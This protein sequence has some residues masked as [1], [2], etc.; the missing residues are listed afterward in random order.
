MGRSVCSPDIGFGYGRLVYFQY[1]KIG[2]S[3]A[4]F[5]CC[6]RNKSFDKQKEDD[7][8]K[9]CFFKATDNSGRADLRCFALYSNQFSAVRDSRISGGCSRFRQSGI[10]Y[11]YICCNG[12]GCFRVL[13]EKVSS[14][15]VGISCG[16]YFGDVSAL[17][18]KRIFRNI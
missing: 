13:R 8:L 7:R 16:M 3:F 2:Y 18:F 6:H 4:V 17:S 5:A 1:G 11:F 12:C 15:C 14:Y 9:A 10:S